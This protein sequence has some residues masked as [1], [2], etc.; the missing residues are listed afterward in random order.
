MT[1][2]RAIFV[3]LIVLAVLDDA[4]LAWR[5]HH[6]LPAG[7]SLELPVFPYANGWLGA[8]DAFSVPLAPDKSLWLFG[9]TYVGSSDTKL[10]SQATTMIHNSIGISTCR[11]GKGCSMRYYWAGAGSAKPRSFFDSG[12]DDLWYW[13]LDGYREGDKLFLPLLVV[14]ERPGS[15]LGD[16]FGWII[17]GTRWA[18]VTNLSAPPERWKISVRDLTNAK[19][20]PGASVVP[21]GKYLLLYTEVSEGEG[22]GYMTVLRVARDR[23]ADPAARWE[24]IG[25]DGK[26]HAAPPHGDAR[27][28]IDQPISEMSVRYHPA[29][30]EWV[31]ISPGPEFP[32]PRIVARTAA[33][34]LGPWSPPKTIFEFPEM[35]PGT[36]GYDKDTFCY[37]TKEHVEFEQDSKMV[38]TYACY[39][40][41][42]PKAKENM[43]IYRPQVVVLD[44]PK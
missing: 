34:P 7:A 16:A 37:A 21:Y 5:S 25:E 27:D 23:L 38:V 39:S 17:A 1:P 31:A 10:R 33:S 2:H 14:R 41:S 9:D 32:S 12:R 36:P 20:W 3:L 43:G 26:W 8:D 15:H 29:E 22:K 42:T 18:E 11:P 28:V 13:P 24:Y 4:A 40:F 6:A 35:K 19:L 44:V 30:R